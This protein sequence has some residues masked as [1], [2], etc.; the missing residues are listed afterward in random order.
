[1]AQWYRD[2]MILFEGAPED[3]V[4]HI[5]HVPELRKGAERIGGLNLAAILESVE[6]AREAIEANTNVQLTLD[7]L[8]LRVRDHTSPTEKSA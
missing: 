6:D 4:I 7:T 5:A 1:M 2:M 8:L 3:Q